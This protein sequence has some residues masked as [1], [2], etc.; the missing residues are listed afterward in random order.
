MARTK[1]EWTGIVRSPG[2]LTWTKPRYPNTQTANRSGMVPAIDC[3]G[4]D[5]RR[6]FLTLESP[7]SASF[8]G[9]SRER[10]ISRLRALAATLTA[11]ADRMESNPT[12]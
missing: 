3:E 6:W 2:G 1:A 5:G 11:E 7:Y 9:T 8:E 10:Y 12:R 4:P